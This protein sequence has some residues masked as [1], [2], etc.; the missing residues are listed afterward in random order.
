MINI[1]LH[2]ILH[3]QLSLELDGINI[4]YAEKY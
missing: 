4:C 2:S 1:M 3:I